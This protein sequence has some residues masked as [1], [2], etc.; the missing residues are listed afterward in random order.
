MTYKKKCSFGKM[1]SKGRI[2]HD[3][4]PNKLKKILEDRKK[5]MDAWKEWWS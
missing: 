4:K 2:R 5:R 1:S 3:K